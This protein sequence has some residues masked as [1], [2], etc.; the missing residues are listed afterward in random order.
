MHLLFLCVASY[1]WTNCNPETFITE[2]PDWDVDVSA[3]SWCGSVPDVDDGNCQP[4]VGDG[5]LGYTGKLEKCD[6]LGL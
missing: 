4:V 2:L 1:A 3:Q 5:L 6:R